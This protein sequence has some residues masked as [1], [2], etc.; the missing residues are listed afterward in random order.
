MPSG[1][2]L[3]I[4]GAEDKANGKTILRKFVS[5][6]GGASARICILPTASENH[7]LGERYQELFAELGVASPRVLPLYLPEEADDPV[8]AEIL[9]HATGVFLTGG[10]QN[11]ILAVLEDTLCYDT[12]LAAWKRGAVVGGTSAGASALSDPMI[13]GGSGGGLPR[14]GIVRIARGL[15]LTRQLIIDQHFR[16]RDRLGR[17]IAAVALTHRAFGLGIDEDT[18]AI[19]SPAGSLEVIGKG[20]VTIVDGRKLS[21][22]PPGETEDE[23]VRLALANVLIHSLRSAQRFDLRRGTI[24]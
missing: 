20:T 13:S 11:K 17:L 3:A 4:G 19:I 10:D 22:S 5:L 21:M 1:T 9:G 16:E 18:A 8:S 23:T 14:P 2:L 7:G 24:Q 15:G 12:L 6:A